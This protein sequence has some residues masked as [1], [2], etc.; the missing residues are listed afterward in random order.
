[1]CASKENL[2]KENKISEDD[3]VVWRIMHD[4]KCSKNF[5]GTSAAM[6]QEAASRLF[7]RSEAI[8]F[9][10]ANFGVLMRK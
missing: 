5:E 10:Y 1:M 4:D 7:G 3:F 8:G 6:E 9:R 2:R